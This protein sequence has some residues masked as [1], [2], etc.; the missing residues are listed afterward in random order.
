[1]K[2]LVADLVPSQSRSSAYGALGFTEGL[3]ALPASLVMGWIWDVFGAPAAFLTG[4]ALAF[5]ALLLL[6]GLPAF[7]NPAKPDRAEAPSG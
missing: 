5:L 4:S 1:M 6:A 2:A 3:V 7:R